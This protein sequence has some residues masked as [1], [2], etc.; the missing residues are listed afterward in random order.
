VKTVVVA[1]HNQHKVAEISTILDIPGWRFVTLDDLGISEEAVENAD[2]FAGNA[3]IKARF[4]FER[5]GKAAI[6]D[7]SGLV[8]DALD[9]EPGVY[10]SR[11]A[12]EPANDAANNVKLLRALEGVPEPERTARFVCAIAFIDEDGSEI[13]AQGEFEGMIAREP[14]GNGG[15]GYDP[16]FLPLEFGGERTLAELQPAEKNLISHRGKVLAQLRDKLAAPSESEAAGGSGVKPETETADGS[17]D[18]N[19]PASAANPVR[20]VAFDFDGTLIDASSPVRLIARL[21]RDHIMSKRVVAKSGLWGMRYKM[22]N[23]LDQRVPRRYIFSSFKNFLATDAN[24]IMRNLY[25]E[26]L[27]AYLRPQA[28][29]RIKEHQQAGEVVMIVSASFEPI[30]EEVS[31]EIGAEAYICTRMEIV[32]GIY[33]GEALSDPPEG[34]QKLIQFKNWANSTYGEGNWQL[35]YAY[36]DHF[37]DIALMQLASH[38]VA[39]DPDRRLERHAQENGCKIVAWPVKPGSG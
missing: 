22:G 13:S 27:R 8:V 29:Q 36:G 19:A 2:S 39:V 30:V 26:D 23:E 28:L 7:D 18:K 5:T 9:G 4:A 10:S 25:F 15:F 24:A 1:T 34:E 16:L 21:S 32:D 20:I 11:Y 31:R 3:R 14:R 12:G 38:P 33:T 6:A 37:S 17:G 35:S